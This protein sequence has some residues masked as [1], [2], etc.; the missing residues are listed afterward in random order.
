MTFIDK[1]KP[2]TSHLFRTHACFKDWNDIMRTQATA[3]YLLRSFNIPFLN[4]FSCLIY[5]PNPFIPPAYILFPR[6]LLAPLIFMISILTISYLLFL[7]VSNVHSTPCLFFPMFT[8][9]CIFN[10]FLCTHNHFIYLFTSLPSF[11]QLLA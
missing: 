4:G 8:Y 10:Y 7:T 2:A 5:R 3:Q 1:K 11:H 6:Y 9:V